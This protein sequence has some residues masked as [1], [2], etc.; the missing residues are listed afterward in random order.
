[1]GIGINMVNGEGMWLVILGSGTEVER[2]P[3]RLAIIMTI[4]SLL[5]AHRELCILYPSYATRFVI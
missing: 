3:A 5:H 4:D 1:M 2:L